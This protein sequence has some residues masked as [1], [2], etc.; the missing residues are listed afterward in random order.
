MLAFRLS[1]SVIGLLVL[2]I[3]GA[4][5]GALYFFAP[6]ITG[7]IQEVRRPTGQA[8]AVELPGGATM[9]MVWVGRGSFLMGSPADEPGRDQNEGPQ[10]RVTISQGFYIGKYEI[11]QAQ[12]TSVMHAQPWAGKSHV[13]ENPHHPA[14]YISWEDVQEFTRRLNRMAGAEVYRLPTAAEWEYACRA[15]TATPWSFG[16]DDSALQKYAWYADNTWEVD[17]RYGHAV[18]TKLPNPWGLH[19]MHGNVWEWVQDW[20]SNEPYSS[21]SEV[22]PKGPTKGFLRV[23]RGGAFGN[24]GHVLRSANRSGGD[25]TSRNAGTGA[26]LVR[27]E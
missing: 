3:L 14:V 12:W 10:H 6:G 1:R 11:T 20:Y 23:G 18:G 13:E 26:R 19:D 15:G 27:Q 8:I 4:L 17:E 2:A 22:D 25:P 24:Y 5:A 9:D 21:S 7:Y 16:E